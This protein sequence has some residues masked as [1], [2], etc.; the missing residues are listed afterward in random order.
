MARQKDRTTR[1]EQQERQEPRKAR[2]DRG[3]GAHSGAEQQA[4]ERTVPGTASAREGYGP[5]GGTAGGEALEGVERKRGR[6]GAGD[7]ARR[8]QRDE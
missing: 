6:R 1:S 8:E 2:P 4:R 3:P 5:E 7:E